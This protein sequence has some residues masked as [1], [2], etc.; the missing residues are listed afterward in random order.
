[1][2][3]KSCSICNAKILRD[4][5]RSFF[6]SSLNSLV[7]ITKA[8]IYTCDKCGFSGVT[9]SIRHDRLM[10]YYS[11]YYNAKA[12][13][14]FQNSKFARLKT[15]T[16][17]FNERYMGQ[18]QTLSV[19]KALKK[20]TSYLEIGS[21]KGDLFNILIHSGLGGKFTVLEPQN[22][23]RMILDHYDVEAID[24]DI[25]DPNALSGQKFDVIFLSHVLEHFNPSDVKTVITNIRK[26]LN[27]DG[28]FL[29]E[30]PHADLDAYP[31][32]CE[33]IVP[34][35]SFFSKKS[36]KLLMEQCDLKV[37]YCET[38]SL[39]QREKDNV[40]LIQAAL[41]KGLLNAVL[42]EKDRM[43]INHYTRQRHDKISK[44]ERWKASIILTCATLFGITLTAK[45]INLIKVLNRDHEMTRLLNQSNVVREHGENIRLLMKL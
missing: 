33:N 35:L 22:A 3:E 20:D 40:S 30:I 43:M 17:I 31:E 12:D 42:D 8:S 25:T 41:D 28:I 15:K 36:A 1:M 2:T 5:Y 34:H 14:A 18:L 32:A 4:K 13:K 27:D 9:E 16:Y 45:V 44:K 21:G 39:S 26:L 23:A 19:F 29:C 10:L 6:P 37:I 11:Q 38:V 7:E 24:G